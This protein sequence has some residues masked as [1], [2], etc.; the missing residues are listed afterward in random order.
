MCVCEDLQRN[1]LND[2]ISHLTPSLL[3][4]GHDT[5]FGLIRNV[6]GEDGQAQPPS[7]FCSLVLVPAPKYLI[8]PAISLYLSFNYNRRPGLN[9]YMPDT[10][11]ENESREE[12][13]ERVCSRRQ[14]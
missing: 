12:A 11:G 7:F 4:H 14:T 5:A 8:A 9:N 1:L 3:R 13:R 10:C 6:N 2:Y